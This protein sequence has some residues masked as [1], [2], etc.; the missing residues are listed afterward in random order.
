M[1]DAV[2]FAYGDFLEF[3]SK[4]I[5]QLLDIPEKRTPESMPETEAAWNAECDE[6]DNKKSTCG[7]SDIVVSEWVPS[8]MEDIRE[9]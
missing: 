9:E 6:E 3:I 7:C 5:P 4:P 1:K 8:G 2:S